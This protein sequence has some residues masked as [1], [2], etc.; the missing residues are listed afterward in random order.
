MVFFLLA[1][2]TPK[3]LVYLVLLFSI[4][5]YFN[6]YFI[7]TIPL[8]YVVFLFRL[9]QYLILRSFPSLVVNLTFIL[10]FFS[11]LL[12]YNIPMYRPGIY[13]CSLP[14]AESDEGQLFISV[15]FEESQILSLISCYALH[16]FAIFLHFSTKGFFI[17]Q[18][19]V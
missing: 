18:F 7:F 4:R 8:F 11:A 15:L 5:H 9:S 6:F 17:F 3:L 16:L 19:P 13:L 14:T 2:K 1:L 12:V 10:Q